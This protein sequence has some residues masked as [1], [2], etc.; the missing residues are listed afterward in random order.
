MTLAAESNADRIEF[1]DG[2]TFTF[3]ASATTA[4]ATLT[5]EAVDNDV[6]D[7][8][9]TIEL[10]A[11][12][13][14]TAVAAPAAVE[15][16]VVDND[17]PTVSIAA[18]EVARDTGHLY[19]AE[20]DANRWELTRA[21]LTDET[22]TVD[23]SVSE[24]GGDFVDDAKESATQT[25]VFSA[26]MDTT[27]Y[28]P[29]TDD[30]VD[31]PHGTV[32]LTVAAGTG[33]APG[34]ASSASVAV[35]DDDGPLLEVSIDASITVPEGM[36]AVFGAKA[37]NSD[38]TLT[39][40]GD[41]ERLFGL[42]EVAVDA[43]SAD[44]TATVADSDYT[45][46]DGPVALDTF[47]A[48]P[49]T[50]GGGRW[51][52][53][54]SV[55]TTEDMVTEGSQD[56]TVTL[57]LPAGTDE[58]IVL[59]SGDEM[60]TA[61]IT[62]GPSV[63]LTLSDDELDEG[64]TE[65]VTA[66]VD[67]V[68]DMPF[69]VTLAAESNAD[70]I[71]FPDGATF[72]F[73]ASAAS[74][75][76]TLTVEAVDNDVDDGDVT[77]ELTATPS[78]AAVTVTT[79]VELTVVDDDDPQVSIAAPAGATDDFLYE[80]EAATDELQYQW[81]LTREGLIDETLTV[82]LSVSEALGDFVDAAKESATQTVTFAA[83]EMTVGYTPITAEDTTND[84]HGTVTVTVQS[85]ADSYD[86]VSGS[87]AAATVAVRDDDGEL[88]TVTLDLDPATL[89]VKEGR[90]A[91]LHAEAE[92][93][94]GTFDT[95]AHMARLFGTL[96]QA[97]V[98]ASTEAS[99][100]TGAATAG[101]DYTALAAETVALPFA[102]FEPGG[103]GVLRSRV[104]LPGIATAEDDVNDP[105]ETFK[106][107]L[108]A[109]A[110]Q[111]ARIAVSTTAA[112]VTISE[113]AIRLCSGT[114]A[115]TC[116]DINEALATRNTE[117]RVEVFNAG[118][119]GTVCD[120]YWSNGDGN[121][122]CTQMGYPGAERVFWSSHFGG[123]ARG[124]E[125][126][127][128]NLQCVGNEK[129]LLKCRRRGNPA[130]GDHN[131]SDRRHVEDAGVRCLAAETAAHG[132][133]LDPA[134]LT[135]APGGT[136]RYWLS[137]TKPLFSTEVEDEGTPEEE[138]TYVPH[139][140][141]VKPTPDAG[142]SVSAPGEEAGY[143]GFATLGEP[144]TTGTGGFY[145]WS[146]GQHVDVSVPAGTRPGEYKV[147]HTMRP[148]LAY[149]DFSVML[150]TLTVTVAAPTSVSGPAPVSATV[151][152]RDAS[153]RFDAPLDASFA[154]STSDFAVLADGRRVAVT[155]AWTAG[156]ALLLELAEPATGA[157]RLAYVPSAAA[158][159]GGRDGAPVSPFETLALA[160]PRGR[161]ES[162]AGAKLLR[163]KLPGAPGELADDA[164]D[165]LTPD[166][167][168]LSAMDA[169]PKL[170]G[171]PGLEA[172]LADALRDA[173]GPVAAT[174]A[175]PRR[176]VADLSGLGA[177][178]ELRRVNLAGNAV[179]DAGPLALLADLER[180][181]L[182]GNAVA[183]LWPLSGLAELRVLDLSGNRVVDVTALAGLPRLRVLELSGNAIV[184]LSPLGM[185]PN[186]EYLGVA[187]N[188]VT[189]VTA[190]ANLHALTR[191]DLDGN[192]VV[193]A[194][195]LGDAG[196]LVWLRLSGNRLTTLDGLGR[197]TQLRWVWVA[198]NPLPDGAMIVAWPERAW[199][200]E[201]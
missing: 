86:A 104:A 90:E 32:T 97:S 190:L 149:P 13:S 183:D 187:G 114:A 145:G 180:L 23:L 175:A 170:E 159:L 126:W 129:D 165:A 31:E 64:D 20:A 164:P 29:I 195:P 91:Q 61:T 92:T 124:T 88:V 45:A 3:V 96:T 161:V 169:A 40:A 5:V 103:D 4:S 131:C 158:P 14:V 17:D 196:R 111:D 30:T 63:T 110:D 58:Q 155:G 119:W 115:S 186:L 200:D 123:A 98:E 49:G 74:A 176:A 26:G 76:A 199:V 112:T 197:L 6:D 193:D 15:L 143:L 2:T 43:Q 107:K 191:L 77:I 179:T 65:T 147:T 66:T 7:G 24:T 102:D 99:T 201:R 71:A 177:V 59:K 122:A 153:V 75:S 79:A 52:D 21:G 108:A 87:G 84:A 56:F 174:L 51:I 120:D 18:P 8:D 12:P 113:G 35:R 83:D 94:A 151:S 144:S 73:A 46:F 72:T 189:D 134:T 166:V 109:P 148:L 140:V 34:T 185:L 9:V 16:T 127:L 69:T 125:I 50:P 142:L 67:P 78:D 82:N 100:G 160:R 154:P 188:R 22:L 184:D 55:Q 42:T 192:A 130:V 138:T 128:D 95:A 1:P 198:D 132:A 57:S 156:R 178:P 121:V 163:R 162:F 133:K 105:D 136:A 167:P 41:L 150:P 172:A 182:S 47:E 70:R 39:A 146:Y 194:A 25:A 173:P 11:T 80:F 54:V 168:G 157:V 116:T 28:T 117:G 60:G 118:V 181:D 135:I 27:S 19:E 68:H 141:S 139:S 48:V 44:G 10:T 38:G 85:V 33:Y 101:T 171:A 81:V 89:T 93:E 53:N 137:L 152:G 36:A 106:V 62:E 37:E